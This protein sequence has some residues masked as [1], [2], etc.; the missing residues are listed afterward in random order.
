M[1]N[2]SGAFTLTPNNYGSNIGG[3]SNDGWGVYNID[4]ARSSGI[5]QSGGTV[6]PISKKVRFIIKF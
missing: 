2:P 3:G 4:S 6:R 1:G 5:Y